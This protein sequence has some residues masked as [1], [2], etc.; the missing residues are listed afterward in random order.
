MLSRIDMGHVIKTAEGANDRGATPL[1]MKLRDIADQAGRLVLDARREAMRISAEARAADG[2]LTRQ[3]SQDGYAE[4]FERGRQEGYS[5]GRAHALAESR[6]QLSCQADQLTLLARRIID[7]VASARQQVIHRAESQ[8]LEFAIELASRIVGA[9]AV[10]NIDAAKVNLAK[11][12]R[13]APLAGRATVRVNPAQLQQLL[14]HVSTLG[15]TLECAESVRL[16]GDES[17]SP[18]GVKL[19]TA[20]GEIDATIETQLAGI[21]RML[22]GS[23]GAP[24]DRTYAADLTRQNGL[25]CPTTPTGKSP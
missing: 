20:S 25:R 18:G 14:E 12:L 15:E 16:V 5:Q 23:P 11:T 2:K 22:L 6:E 10:T 3:A 7:E 9:V 21:A 8:M 19:T 17:I 4:G 24:D 13:L 1:A